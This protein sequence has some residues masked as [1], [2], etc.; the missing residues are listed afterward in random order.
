MTKK[1]YDKNGRLSQVIE[2]DGNVVGYQ[3]YAN[4]SLQTQT[5]QGTVTA[6][7]TYYANNSLHT[8]VNKRSATVL[9][10]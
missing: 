10:S 1:V 3:Y 6:N 2:P 9:E 8:L 7:Y 5:L 4:G